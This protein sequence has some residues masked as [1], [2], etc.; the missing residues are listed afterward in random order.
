MSSV[1]ILTLA[2]IGVLYTAYLR[3]RRDSIRLNSLQ[4][5][6]ELQFPDIKY[7]YDK[8]N[9]KSDRN[10]TIRIE[11][12]DFVLMT[13]IQNISIANQTLV[14][15][16]SSNYNEASILFDIVIQPFDKALF[17]VD[18][19]R[20]Y[21]HEGILILWSYGSPTKS[22]LEYI[23]ELNFLY[24]LIPDEPKGVSLK[25]DSFRVDK[26]N[27]T[28]EL[29]GKFDDGN[30]YYLSINHES[31]ILNFRAPLNSIKNLKNFK[32]LDDSDIPSN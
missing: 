27:S 22:S 32:K 16:I 19:F 13:D 15:R 2:L 3:Y 29:F 4:K 20:N 6:H 14:S 7:D 17:E 1:Y 28:V 25:I 8:F 12:S 18:G 23:E 30:E 10:T 21:N 24:D 26:S 5:R 9:T 11:D 31:Y